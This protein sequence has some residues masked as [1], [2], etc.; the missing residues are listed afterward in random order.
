MTEHWVDRPRISSSCA[1]PLPCTRLHALLHT[2]EP[3]RE[4]S[5]TDFVK[6]GQQRLELLSQ[7]DTRRDEKWDAKDRALASDTIGDPRSHYILALVYCRSE[8]LRRRFV[9]WESRLFAH[10]IRNNVRKIAELNNIIPAESHSNADGESKSAQQDEFFAVPFTQVLEL[11]RQRKCEV[12]N[13]MALV[14]SDQVDRNTIARQEEFLRE[15][16]LHQFK[17]LLEARLKKLSDMYNAYKQDELK[18]SQLEYVCAQIKPP[19]RAEAKDFTVGNITGDSLPSLVDPSFPLCMTYLYNGLTADSHLRHSG[20]QQFGLF[21]KG[22]GMSVEASL[23]FWR[24]AFAKKIPADKFEKTYAYNIRHNYG[25]EGKRVKYPPMGCHAIIDLPQP[26]HGEYHG[27]PYKT[28]RGGKLRQ[29]V[30]QRLSAHISDRFALNAAIKEI[31]ELSEG[32]HYQLA[33]Q[34]M[35]GLTHDNLE[36]KNGVNHPNTYFRESFDYLVAKRDGKTMDI[37]KRLIA[38][39]SAILARGFD[40]LQPDSEMATGASQPAT[41]SPTDL[42]AGFDAAKLGD[43]EDLVKQ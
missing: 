2:Q 40:D 41:V 29:L 9:D 23:E 12:V 27:C 30:E 6:L 43:L 17:E 24:H 21:L 39:S 31:L 33:C 16:L 14:R 20:R 13:G 15:R 5:L 3:T 19:Q 10:R 32:E 34:R 4:I 35:F 36:P 22:I 7:L 1:I 25:L 42:L 8:D 38:A 37:A 11:V 28:L 26:Q 18:S